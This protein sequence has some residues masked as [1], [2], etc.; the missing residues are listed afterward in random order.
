MTD[1]E[2]IF[3]FN[4]SPILLIGSGIS[5]RYIEN[6]PDWIELLKSVADRM[7]IKESVFTAYLHD[8]RGKGN[9]SQTMAIVAS[10]LNKKLIENIMSGTIDPDVLFETEDEM[11]QYN[12]QVD[13]VKILAASFFK[14]IKLKENSELRQELVALKKLAETIPCVITTNYDMFLE[15]HVFTD[16][17]V[18]SRVSDYYY[19]D[20]EGIGEI[21][22]IHG[23]LSEPRTMILG[24]RDYEEFRKNSKIVSAKI[25]SALCDY[26]MVIIGYSMNDEDIKA[27]IY[28]LISS[29]DPDRLQ[30]IEKN[31]VYVDQVPGKK[32]VVRKNTDF[33]HEDKNMRISTIETGNFIRLYEEMARIAPSMSPLAVRKARRM[34]RNIILSDKEGHDIA[35]LGVDRIDDVSAD[36]FAVAFADKGTLQRMKND[37]NLYSTDQMIEDALFGNMRFNVES[38]VNWIDTGTARIAST[39]Y[40]PI[41]YFIQCAGMTREKYSRRMNDFVIMKRCQ[42]E[43]SVKSLEK[44]PAIRMSCIG[45]LSEVRKLLF[46]SG[47]KFYRPDIVFY[48]CYVGVLSVNEARSLLKEIHEKGMHKGNARSAFKRAVTYLA[49][50]EMNLGEK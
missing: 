14:D 31:I 27:V 17:R 12:E 44:S 7:G 33:K 43:K 41:F 47:R 10:E 37:V 19:S 15:K 49:F 40:V 22:K 28:D 3:D 9:D 39:E 42:F 23:T 35:L 38:V 13:P 45:G 11:R 50:K 48:Y 34:L 20:S 18:Y 1:D 8:A 5:K 6:S 46:E 4:R 26:P 2:K 36:K 16:Y 25:L 30:E 29:L 32:E 24:Q 21:Y